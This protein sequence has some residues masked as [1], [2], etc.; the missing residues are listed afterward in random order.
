MINKSEKSQ[1]FFFFNTSTKKFHNPSAA[2]IPNFPKIKMES[3][4]SDLNPN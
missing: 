3:Q 4:K 1:Y 2:K